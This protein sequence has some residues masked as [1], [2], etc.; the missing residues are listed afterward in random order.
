MSDAN[1]SPRRSERLKVTLHARISAP[2]GGQAGVTLVNITPEGCCLTTGGMTL[3]PG[4][5]VL[6]R[7][8]TGDTLS[9]IVRWCDGSS[10]GLAF[11]YFLP[12]GRVEFLRRE[13]T[14]FLA[15]SDPMTGKVQRS[16]C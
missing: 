8:E 4:T 13:H 2:D 11:E 14:S 7:L 9:G 16:V 3:Q 1:W 10:A 6:V 5:A 15:E 12:A